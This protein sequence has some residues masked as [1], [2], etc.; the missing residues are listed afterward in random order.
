MRLKP[1]PQN[2]RAPKH[3]VIGVWLVLALFAG[4]LFAAPAQAQDAGPPTCASAAT[5][6]DGDGWGFENGVSCRVSAGTTS[7]DNGQGATPAPATNTGGSTPT[8]AS[9]ATDPDGDGWGF[10]NGVSCRVSADASSSNQ[11]PAQNNND[12]ADNDEQSPAPV[13]TNPS[14]NQD[15]SLAEAIRVV[16]PSASSSVQ[17]RLTD[18]FSQARS[19]VDDSVDSNAN[20]VA[21]FH[22]LLLDN[23]FT[24]GFEREVQAIV[25]G[26]KTESFVPPPTIEFVPVAQIDPSTASQ[27]SVNGLN[28]SLVHSVS[29]AAVERSLL[30]TLP[31]YSVE[32]ANEL[33]SERSR[34]T[35]PVGGTSDSRADLFIQTQIELEAALLSLPEAPSA[36]QVEEVEILSFRQV[37]LLLNIDVAERS[38]LWDVLR[39]VQGSLNPIE[40]PTSLPE[41][42]SGNG[43][44]VVHTP[45]SRLW[46]R[47]S[48]AERVEYLGIDVDGWDFALPYLELSLE[49]DE[50]QDNLEDWFTPLFTLGVGIILGAITGG[51]ASGLAAHFGVGALGV[52]ATGAAVGNYTTTYFL[53]GSTSQAEKAAWAGLLSAGVSHYVKVPL[54]DRTHVQRF[55]LAILEGGI[56]ALDEDGSFDQALATSLAEQ[57]VPGLAQFVESLDNTSPF[58]AD[59]GEVLAVSY[60]RNGF[61][62]DETAKDLEDFLLEEAGE[63]VG[64]FTGGVLSDEFGEVGVAIG[65]LAGIA[66][67]SDGDPGVVGQA[68]AQRLG[69]LA[70]SGVN[71][72]FHVDESRIAQISGDLVAI[73]FDAQL[74]PEN[75]RA[76]YLDDR[77]S[78]Y[79]FG[80]AGEGLSNAANG[81]LVRAN[82]GQSNRLIEATTRLVNVAVSNLWRDG[83]DYERFIVDYVT[84]EVLFAIQSTLQCGPDGVS[85]LGDQIIAVTL[86]GANSGNAENINANLTA[87]INENMGTGH[88]QQG[89][90]TDGSTVNCRQDSSGQLAIGSVTSDGNI[91]VV[92]VDEN[93]SSNVVQLEEG[94][95]GWA[96]TAFN[97]E[98]RVEANTGLPE[99]LDD[100]LASIHWR[101]LSSAQSVFHQ[102]TSVD[103]D[104]L[105]FIHD[106]GRE[107]VYYSGGGRRGELVTDPRF[108]GSF[109]YVNAT[110]TPE[111]LLDIQGWI[112]FAFFGFGHVIA[113]VVPFLL[114]GAS[115]GESYQDSENL[116]GLTAPLDQ[117]DLD[118]RDDDDDGILAGQDIDDK[119]PN[120]LARAGTPFADD[121]GDGWLIFEDPHPMNS[122]LPRPGED[123]HSG[124]RCN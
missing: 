60:I 40:A 118:H 88:C 4:V 74:R 90:G 26:G 99:T 2:R 86:S 72:F 103:G 5:D 87:L 100:A 27:S 59:L 32:G 95:A 123:V 7:T 115:R 19:R 22:R 20:T 77:V 55:S 34:L 47:S 101:L 37:E 12:V 108:A 58:L 105:K 33:G 39:L 76:R 114:F 89:G 36:S 75:E 66:V 68:A 45:F 78:Q 13:V 24:P 3:T 111:E 9:A 44:N 81:A 10:E 107:A 91:R 16:V 116:E 15:P 21:E 93:G 113:D 42:K 122:A 117:A 48:Q 57:Y 35:R 61:E 38:H 49:M 119:D 102:D 121:D 53:T 11:T 104:E 70:E 69:A 17:S 96:I 30:L 85:E 80:L 31:G 62:W 56:A 67:S 51:L 79:V 124:D 43:P 63:F 82:D 8:C 71:A 94:D 64:D 54:A 1:P 25:R 18:L 110:P 98:D 28:A 65:E 120:Q 14:G 97:F 23:G 29:T 50:A 52:A 106:D 92:H 6:P 109:N 112:E 46:N 83:D 84:V 73:Y 41:A